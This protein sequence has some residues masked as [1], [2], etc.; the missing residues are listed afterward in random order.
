METADR[1]LYVTEFFSYKTKR[2]LLSYLEPDK[3][4]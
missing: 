1:K 2:V 3:L 4:K